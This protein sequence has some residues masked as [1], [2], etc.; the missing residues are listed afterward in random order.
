[1][2]MAYCQYAQGDFQAAADTMESCLQADSSNNE[3]AG[4]LHPLAHLQLAKTLDKLGRKSEAAE[5][6][7]AALGDKRFALDGAGALLPAN[8]R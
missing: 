4:L 6:R 5:Q 1:M 8:G 7:K 3:C 2:G